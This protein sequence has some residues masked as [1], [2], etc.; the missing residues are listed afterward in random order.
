MDKYHKI[1]SV[2]K[3]DPTNKMKTF[4]VGQYSRPEFGY[5][6]QNTWVFTEKVDGTNVRIHWDGQEVRFGGRTDNAQMPVLLMSVMLDTEE[7]T[8]EIHNKKT[9][10]PLKCLDTY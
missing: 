6:E 10:Y 7:H 3:R 1:Q 8:K 2:Y 4:L 9:I 5:L